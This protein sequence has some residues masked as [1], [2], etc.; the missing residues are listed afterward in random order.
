MAEAQFHP[1]R[2]RVNVYHTRNNF[3][4]TMP[5]TFALRLFHF[6]TTAGSRQEYAAVFGDLS[7]FCHFLVYIPQLLFNFRRGSVSGFSLSSTIL[8]LIGSSFLFVNSMY[9]EAS[10]PYI[11]YGLLNTVEQCLFLFQFLIYEKTVR[12]LIFL[13]TPLIPWFLCEFFPELI[14]LTDLVKPVTQ[15]VSCFP[16]IHACIR[17]RTTAG[18]SMYGQHLHFVGGV[19]GFMMLVLQQNFGLLEWFLFA[20]SFLQAYSIYILAAWY[21]ELRWRDTADE[22]SCNEGV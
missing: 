18:L 7:S 9:K 11:L 8:K 17:L 20:C 5:T 4:Q 15:V 12:P 3:F 10:F 19:F 6:V 14:K 22:K 16:Q 1:A 13:G 21:G 2:S